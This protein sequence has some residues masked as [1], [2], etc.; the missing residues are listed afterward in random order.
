MLGVKV[1][2]S[3]GQI[4]VLKYNCRN[5]GYSE[6]APEGA[7]K[8][9]ETNTSDDQSSYMQYVLPHLEHDPTLPR[10]HMIKCANPHCS[11]PDDA[12]NEVIYIKYDSANLRYLY[13]CVHCS[14]FW[15]KGGEMI[16]KE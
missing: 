15:K 7:V 6:N 8:I 14:A 10:T 12:E 16:L 4:P 1:D 13:N 2:T 11:K 3:Q 5:C 9:S